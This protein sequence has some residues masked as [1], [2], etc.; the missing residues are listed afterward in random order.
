MRRTLT[1]FLT[2]VAV[3]VASSTSVSADCL[4]SDAP[5]IKQKHDYWCWAA[6]MEIIAETFGCAVDQCRFVEKLYVNR[7]GESGH[8]CYTDAQGNCFFTM[9]RLAEVQAVMDVAGLGVPP[10]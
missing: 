2:S 8:C 7:Y 4:R 6:N 5:L 10:V 9:P 1:V 3:G